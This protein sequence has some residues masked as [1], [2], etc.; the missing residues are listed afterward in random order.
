VKAAPLAEM[1]DLPLVSAGRVPINPTMEVIGR[2]RIYVVGDMAY[3]EDE[4]GYP[5]PMLI[6]VANQQGELAA[7]NIVRRL[8]GDREEVFHYSDRGIMATIGRSRAVAWLF[9]RIQLSGWL[10]WQAWLWFHL[11]ALMG[12]RNRLSVFISWVWNYWTYDRSVRIILER[13]PHRLDRIDPDG[14]ETV[15]GKAITP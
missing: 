13:D 15:P 5:Y 11:V 12:F 1:L 3:L 6:P 2:D 10:A 4:D 9:N 8:R 7:R 14:E